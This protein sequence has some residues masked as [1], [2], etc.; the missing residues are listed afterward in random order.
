MDALALA[1]LTPVALSLAPPIPVIDWGDFG[2]LR[3][4]D[5]FFDQTVNRW[6]GEKPAPRLLRTDLTALAAFDGAIE[7]D[8]CALIFH[9]SR[10]GSTLLS[11]LLGT[12]AE[13]LMI[14][15]PQPINA[16][17]M[18][19][20]PDGDAAAPTQAL[21]CLIRALGGRR[22]GEQ[23]YLLKL[24]SWNIR[25]FQLCRQ[26]F[27]AAKIVFV[28]RAPEEV[29]A[30]LRADPPGWLQL[31]RRPT[32]AQSMF[33]IP[34]DAVARLDANELAAH[35]LAAILTA[36]GTAADAGALIVNYAELASA[37]WTRVAPFLGM[38][39]AA[40]DV[41]R[42]QQEARYYAK[43]VGQRIFTGDAPERRRIDARLR[44]LAAGI[45]EP[46]YQAMERRRRAQL[47]T[48]PLGGRVA[49]M[50]G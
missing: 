38:R 42:M 26:A 40:H 47:E 6:A 9:M 7:R 13:T 31:R 50:R 49:I 8:P 34:A 32:W 19:A 45:V 18:A 5:P 14:S 30:S 3:F 29:M 21:R 12:M 24:S 20:P 15:E 41:L 44:D 36:A 1:R 25:R 4:S 35:A 43:D 2:A 33:D 39:L 17:L 27:P 48:D 28:Q 37:T 22:F 10:C 11:R 46:A 16:L 23:R